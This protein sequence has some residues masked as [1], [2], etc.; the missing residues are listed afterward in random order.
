L[1]DETRVS[2]GASLT[3]LVDGVFGRHHELKMGIDYNHLGF[4]VESAFPSNM[5]FQD[6]SGVPDQVTL[7]DGDIQEASGNQTKLFA[8]DGISPRLGVAWDVTKDHKTVARAHYGRFH[9]AFGTVEYQFTDT[10]RQSVQ[11]TARVLG[12]N[13][14]QE[15]SRFT[16]AGNQFVDADIKQPHMDQY[17]VGVERELFADFSASAQYVHREHKQLFGWLDTRSVYVP[18]Q[19]RDPGRDGVAGNADDGC[20]VTVFNLTN[21]GQERRLFTNPDGAWR[22]YRALQLVLQKRFSKNWQLLAGYTRSKAEGS[23]NNAQ[24]DNYGSLTVTQNPFINPNN[25]VNATGRNVSDFPHELLLR[26]SYH[27]SLL[28]GFN[29]GAVYRYVSGQAFGRTAVFRLAQG[30]TTVRVEPR[31]TLP[32]G[33]T[34]QA[35]LR[36]DK[37]IPLG[38]KERRLAV[39][40]D[41]FN[42]T[43]QGVGSPRG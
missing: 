36:F 32:S 18:V 25:A 4:Y 8:Q 24:G 38:A 20:L 21:P 43:N 40:L 30:N 42:A 9:E 2:F 5:S 29:F 19:M 39:Y 12:P 28:G 13:S 10:T 3:R 33:A 31:G 26:G 35:D 41:I 34:R 17:L 7:W 27:F 37:T 16:P 1:L 14:F 22:R 6:R 15:L 11:I 23:V